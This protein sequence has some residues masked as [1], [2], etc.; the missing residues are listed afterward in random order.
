MARRIAPL[1]M[2]RSA[3][4]SL[5]GT[6]RGSGTDAGSNLAPPPDLIPG[7]GGDSG[8]QDGGDTSPTIEG[9]G[10]QYDP[11][12]NEPGIAYVQGVGG[13]LAWPMDGPKTQAWADAWEELA[14]ALEDLGLT[15]AILS[16]LAGTLGAVLATLG[17]QWAVLALYSAL[18]F[19]FSKLA[20]EI[21]HDPPQRDYARIVSLSSVGAVRYQAFSPVADELGE[22]LDDGVRFA[23]ALLDS[24]ERFQGARD[25]QD[26]DWACNHALIARG[27]SR[28]LR[29][30]LGHIADLLRLLAKEVDGSGLD[31]ALVDIKGREDAVLHSYVAQLRTGQ[32]SNDQRFTASDTE[33]KIR[34]QMTLL[35][36]QPGT[37]SRRI[38]ML[39][40]RITQ[41]THRL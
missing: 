13:G 7:G 34:A 16:G 8:G 37:L 38:A 9:E 32:R 26:V 4:V 36:S 5:R 29:V 10:G 20:G 41:A 15:L 14:D 3:V 23:Q 24:L 35:S 40:R 27:L 19:C 28:E 31:S 25:A 21:A 6:V 17:A 22:A 1:E 39:S 30:R 2:S 18:A 33:S 11:H 12:R